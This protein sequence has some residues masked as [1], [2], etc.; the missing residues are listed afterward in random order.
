MKVVP[1]L[2]KYNTFNLFYYKGYNS[3]YDWTCNMSEKQ[4]MASV[5]AF[6]AKGF[7]ALGYKYFNLV[8]KS[9]DTIFSLPSPDNFKIFLYLDDDYTLVRSYLQPRYGSVVCALISIIWHC[10]AFNFAC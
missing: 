1:P 9:Y 3:W 10:A 8:K 7:P 2:N 4:L 6:V 5:D